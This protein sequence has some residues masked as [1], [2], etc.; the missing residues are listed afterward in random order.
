MSNNLKSEG[1]SDGKKVTHY[2]EPTDC[3]VKRI[4]VNYDPSGC[5]TGFTFYDTEGECVLQVTS[6]GKFAQREVRLKRGERVVGVK[7]RKFR[8]GTAYHCSLVFVI[9]KIE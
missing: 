8:D 6:G 3:Q 2:M 7:S 9:G 1:M 5:V 4:L